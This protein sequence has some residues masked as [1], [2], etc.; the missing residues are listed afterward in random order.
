MHLTKQTLLVFT[1][2][3]LALTS[4]AEAARPTDIAVQ[5]IGPGPV[6]VDA[7][8]HY[9]IIVE[10][11]SR[12]RADGVRVQIQLPLTATS[13]RAYILGTVTNGDARCFDDG[14]VF[15]C[16]LGRIRRGRAT[17]IGF[18]FSAPFSA[19]ASEIR[20]VAS[21]ADD[22]DLSNNEARVPVE[23]VYVPQ[24]I[25]APAPATV[26]FCSGQGLI[27]FYDCVVS[28]GSTRSY[29][30]DLDANGT[31]AFP[32]PNTAISGVWSQASSEDLFLE[33]SANG[34]VVLSYDGK[35]IGNNCFDGIATFNSPYNAAY[36]VCF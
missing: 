11:V 4:V 30:V 22:T 24:T 13:P 3:S 23:L 28:P 29:T 26:T 18:D 10:N 17:S 32:S 19:V 9:E 27:S 25:S 14:T 2:V 34:Q 6:L 15:E 36:R 1:A 35:G 16:V 20:A 8:G 21:V 12:R 7:P 33:Y 31:V 5:L